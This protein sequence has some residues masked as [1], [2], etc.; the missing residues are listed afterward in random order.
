MSPTTTA[1]AAAAGGVGGGAAA[2]TAFY[3]ASYTVLNR[4]T[5]GILCVL[6]ERVYGTICSDVEK[7]RGGGRHFFFIF[8]SLTCSVGCGGDLLMAFDLGRFE[9]VISEHL[10]L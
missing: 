1:A 3:Q 10:S 7:V 2:H 5:E 9:L 4:F 8:E 6:F